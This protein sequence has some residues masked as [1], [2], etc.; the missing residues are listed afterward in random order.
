VARSN[1]GEAL[2]GLQ[3]LQSSPVAS[4]ILF[5][6]LGYFF[7]YT[8]AVMIRGAIVGRAHA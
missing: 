5:V 3:G 8:A 2:G 1:S 7:C 4:A 6:V